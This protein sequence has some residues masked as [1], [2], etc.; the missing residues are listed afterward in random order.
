MGEMITDVGIDLDGVLYPFSKSFNAYCCERM[1]RLFLPEPTHWNFYED[2]DLD[3][4]TFYQWIDEA[5]QSHQVFSTEDPYEGVLEAWAMLMSIG[6]HIHIITS[7]PRAAWEQTAEWLARH[8]L[9][10]D[11]LHFNKSKGF[12]TKIAKGKSALIDDHIVYYR[13]AKNNGI[14]PV[15]MDRS[16]NQSTD[17]FTRVSSL[18]E[19]VYL[20]KGYNIVMKTEK[21]NESLYKHFDPTSAPFVRKTKPNK[22]SNQTYYTGYEK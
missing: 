2:W 19:F 8:K 16:W 9:T 13:E 4:V 18:L 11:S 21:K 12:L 10:A 7:R 17:E 14:F 22:L 3:E 5:A 1:G 6:V 20:I 15:L